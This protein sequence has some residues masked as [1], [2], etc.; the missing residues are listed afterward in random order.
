MATIDDVA[1]RAG[2]NRHGFPGYE[3]QLCRVSGQM[4]PCWRPPGRLII[5]S[6]V[7]KRGKPPTE[8]F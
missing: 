3:Q 5:R 2:I 4:R 1:A 7:A 6:A 8:Q